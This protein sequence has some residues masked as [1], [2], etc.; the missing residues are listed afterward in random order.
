MK[1]MNLYSMNSRE[2]L[3]WLGDCLAT[4]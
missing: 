1:V 4:M 2:F 3:Y